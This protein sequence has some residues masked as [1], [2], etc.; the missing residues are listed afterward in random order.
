MPLLSSTPIPNSRISSSFLPFSRVPTSHLFRLKIVGLCPNLGC[1]VGKNLDNQEWRNLGSVAGSGGPRSGARLRPSPGGPAAS[2]SS[3]SAQMI[4]CLRRH[5]LAVA[6]NQDT[7]VSVVA[8]AALQ[9]LCR[10]GPDALTSPDLTR[11]A[12]F[13][14]ILTPTMLGPIGSHGSWVLTLQRHLRQDVFLL[15]HETY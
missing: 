2:M 13:C 9:P 12:V 4:R 3:E 11:R 6:G 7:P 14:R 10:G 15:R 5:K 1:H 8:S